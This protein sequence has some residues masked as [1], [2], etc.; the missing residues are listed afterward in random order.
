MPICFDTANVIV[1]KGRLYGGHHDLALG[2]APTQPGFTVAMF[3]R[4]KPLADRMVV[5]NA[6]HIEQIG[7]PGEI[8]H[9]PATRFV[10]GFIGIPPINLLPARVMTPGAVTLTSGGRLAL[11]PDWVAAGKVEVGI[12]PEDVLVDAAGD[13]GNYISFTVEFIERLGADR[14]VHGTLEGSDFIV[15]IH[16]G[17]QMALGESHTLALVPHA[18]HLFDAATGRRC[19]GD[20]AYDA[21]WLV[22]LPAGMA[23]YFEMSSSA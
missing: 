1:S 10:A 4:A 2:R 12:R 6:G 22:A 18:L 8:Y 20:A 5:M 14:L 15:Q 11:P 13:G 9:R 21:D 23:A 19:A 3:D 17:A 16:V 7:A